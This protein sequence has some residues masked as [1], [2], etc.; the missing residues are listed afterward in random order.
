MGVSKQNSK[1]NEIPSTS[2]DGQDR[3]DT[4]DKVTG[5]IAMERLF[6]EAGISTSNNDQELTPEEVKRVVHL[7]SQ[8]NPELESYLHENILSRFE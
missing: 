3:N 1:I 5:D 6:E 8:S 2:R 4:D 7:L